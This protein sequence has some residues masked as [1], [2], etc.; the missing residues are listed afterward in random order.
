MVIELL[1]AG[2]RLAAT[3]AAGAA[4]GL[5]IGGVG[6]RLAMMLLARRN[7]GATG[8]LSDDGFEMGRFTASGTVNLLVVAT[9]IGVLGGGIYSALRSLMIGP[10]WFRLLSITTGP[11]VVVGSML[12]HTGGVDFTLLRPLGLAVGL[13]VLIPFAYALALT[14]L[15]ERLVGPGGW[16]ARA[17]WWLA[18]IPLLAWIPLLPAL[19]LLAAGWWTLALARR[20]D[21]GRAA[22]CSPWAAWTARA[23]LAGA[24][25]A[26][27]I[28]LGRDVGTLA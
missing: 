22:V 2:R 10:Q 24:F 12:V 27:L 1:A 11:A 7:P 23:L 20:T 17:P 26:A 19:V 18:M 21:A 5:V 15:A 25:T 6:G 8:V 16:F 3:T 14:L 9:L 4:A 28:D 13:F